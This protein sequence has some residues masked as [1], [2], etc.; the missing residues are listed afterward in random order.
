MQSIEEWMN[1]Y[2][3]NLSS[4]LLILSLLLHRIALIVTLLFFTVLIEGEATENATQVNNHSGRLWKRMGS[5]SIG[6]L[7]L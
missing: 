1:K 5:D 2:T 7:E 6:C 3:I 4:L